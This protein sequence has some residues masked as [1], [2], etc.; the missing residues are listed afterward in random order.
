MN[1]ILVYI[2]SAVA[3]LNFIRD[4]ANGCESQK[5]IDASKALTKKCEKEESNVLGCICKLNDDDYWKKL[6]DCIQS[7]DTSQ[8]V[9]D[10][11]PSG[12]KQL[13]CD[14]ASAYASLSTL[15][16]TNSLAL[17]DFQGEGSSAIGDVVS[18]LSALSK[19]V[20]SATGTTSSGKTSETSMDASTSSDKTSSKT[21]S[22]MAATMGCGSIIS[23]F[24]LALL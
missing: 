24:V 17:S 2:V 16:P 15:F 20:K 18:T 1:I 10:T 3:A 23:L 11:S 5:C 9:I 6:S 12:L 21:T 19:S 13:Y 22:N 4:F 7:C 14:A 8:D